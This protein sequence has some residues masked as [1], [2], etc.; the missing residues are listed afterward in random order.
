MAINIRTK[1]TPDPTTGDGTPTVTHYE[2]TAAKA[3]A[4]LKQF[5]ALIPFLQAPH[6]ATASFVHSKKGVPVDFITT[7]ASSYDL[8]AELQIQKFDVAAAK[9]MLQHRSAFQ[10]VLL[11]LN[12]L[13][14]DLQFTLDARLASVAADSLQLYDIAK[15]VARASD[16]A[17]VMGRVLDMGK[18]LRRKHP[19]PRKKA[20]NPTSPAPTQPAPTT[21]PPAHPA[22]QLKE[23]TMGQA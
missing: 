4:L 14:R 17:D 13:Q 2:E 15:G 12:A 1:L 19:K 5:A 16:S 21:P 9:D 20:G 23:V 22:G 10:P 18:A 8:T 3:L 11:Q 7:V 6:P